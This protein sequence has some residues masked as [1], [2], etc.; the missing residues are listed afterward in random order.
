MNPE[1]ER[2]IKGRPK[3]KKPQVSQS[4]PAHF[5]STSVNALKSNIRSVTRVLEHAQNLPLDV[6]IEKERAL[7]GYKQDLE[8]VQHEKERQRMIKKYHMVRFFERQKAT[9]NLKKLRTRLSS[10]QRNSPEEQ[11]TL[12]R[13]IHNAEVD[14]NYTLYHPLTQKYS[15]LFPRK[16]TQEP[17]HG[18]ATSASKTMQAR[19]DKPAMWAVV[20]SCMENGTLQALR[21]GNLRTGAAPVKPL[22][23][24]FH[25][26]TSE[27]K[28]KAKQ[29]KPDATP[30][31]TEQADGSDG[32]FFEE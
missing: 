25:H 19:Q 12:D 27:K 29:S 9:R 26:Q 18:T 4:S 5:T 31:V 3:K 2:L 14:L 13:E 24:S 10:S 11:E 28:Q 20:E 21:D 6:R 32:G 1:R 22:K 15:S 23:S 8:K 16:E 30:I 7:A 17:L